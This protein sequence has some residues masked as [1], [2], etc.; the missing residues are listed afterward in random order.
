WPVQ[1]ALAGVALVAE[2]GVLRPPE[3]LLGFPDVGTSEAEAKRLEAHR[4]HGHVAGEHQEVG[5]RDFLAVLLLDRPQQ[6]TRLV[7]VRV[8]R[9][10]V[11]RGEPLRALSAASAS[12]GNAIG[13]CRMPRHA[14][15]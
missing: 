4:L 5:P 1:I 2:P 12:V 6:S 11:Q 8:V 10:A 3:D 13:A 9:P 15:K 7:D 14:N